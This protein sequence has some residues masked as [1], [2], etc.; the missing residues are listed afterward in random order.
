MWGTW[1]PRNQILLSSLPLVFMCF[2][3]QGHHVAKNLFWHPNMCL[4]ACTDTD[5]CRYL[6]AYICTYS[7]SFVHPY[8]C[9]HLLA[10]TIKVPLY[11]GP[12]SGYLDYPLDLLNYCNLSQR[13]HRLLWGISL[14]HIT[15]QLCIH[16]AMG[17]MERC[18][19]QTFH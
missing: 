13:R 7:P 8:T 10:Q 14:I 18:W 2:P 16:E 11:Q 17:C 5:T 1:A 3:T 19:S 12:R 4:Q 6:F 15:V 9:T